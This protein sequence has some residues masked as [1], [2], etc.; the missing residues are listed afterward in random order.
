MH[1]LIFRGAW[2]LG[3]VTGEFFFFFFF[4]YSLVT[5]QMDEGFFFFFLVSRVGDFHVV[6]DNEDIR[7]VKK[8]KC[9]GVLCKL[10]LIRRF[11]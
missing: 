2:K 5:P 9:L 8:A 3:R 10:S 7:G 6:T 4:F 11:L 1:H